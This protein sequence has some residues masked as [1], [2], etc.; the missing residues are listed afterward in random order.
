MKILWH[1][2]AAHSR[3][4]Y[5]CQ[6]RIT[7]PKLQEL[8]HD[9]AIS[10]FYGLEGGPQTID[11]TKVYPKLNDGY[12]NDVLHAHARDHA[13]GLLEDVAI[14]LLLDVWVMRPE[15]FTAPV[16]SFAWV[17]VDHEPA[18]PGVKNFFAQSDC[19]PVAMS[20]FGERML[21][22]FDPLYVPHAIDTKVFCDAGRDEGR[23]LIDFPEGAFVVGMVAANKGNPSRKSFVEAIQAFANFRKEKKDACLYVHSEASGV[24]HGVNLPNLLAHLELPPECVHFPDQ[25]K[26]QVTGFSEPEMAKM[27]SAFDV[28]LNP[29][30]GE[31]FGIPILEAQACGTPVITTN[32][33]AMTEVGEVGWQ[34]TGQRTWTYLES[35]Q[36]IPDVGQL[37]NCLVQAY[38]QA[39][40]MRRAA[41][42]FA[43]QYDIDRVVPEYW[44]PALAEMERRFAEREPVAVAA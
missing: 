11:G 26:L 43:E 6:T 35:W 20:R 25:Y 21:S 23:A 18:P 42:A 7:V 44:V 27:Y 37:T 17:P 4:G 8:G 14:G 34:V 12:G 15:L 30:T 29:A 22:E 41:R 40:V 33:S 31:G 1:S 24:Y 19:I 2:N 36:V 39:P 9:V 38:G 13:G 32:N 3:T 28:L 16:K 5:G 10:A